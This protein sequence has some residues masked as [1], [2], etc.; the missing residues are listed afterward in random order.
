M[1]PQG[2][3]CTL[4]DGHLKLHWNSQG[5]HRLFDL[6]KDPRELNNLFR[7]DGKTTSAMITALTEYLGSL[8]APGAVPAEQ[9]VE[10]ETLD[11]LKGLGYVK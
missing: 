11:A 8:P 4:I 3:W 6:S 9:T 7:K 2:D 5:N 1:S 10:Q